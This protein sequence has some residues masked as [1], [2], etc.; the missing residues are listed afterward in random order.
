[1]IQVQNNQTGDVE[2][3]DTDKDLPSLVQSGAVSIPDKDYE[4]E[5]PEGD[6]YQVGAQG[7]L[8]AVKQG[9]KYR[10][11]DVL[12][13]EELQNKYGDSTAKALLYGGLRGATLGISDAILTKTGAVDPEELSAVKEFNP[14]ASNVG[15]IGAT[16]A[17]MLLSGGSSTAAGAISKKYLPSLLNETAEY[18]GKRAAA[19][20]TSNVAK[21]AVELGASG[22]IEGAAMGL[23]QTISEASLGDAE[24]NAESLLQNVGTGALIGGGLGATFGAGIEYAKKAVKG[25]TDLIK[26]QIIEHSDLPAAEKKALLLEQESKSEFSRVAN[27]VFEDKEFKELAAKNGWPTTPGMETNLKPF[28]TLEQ[29]IA[30]GASAPAVAIQKKVDD[31]YS[32]I[33]KEITKTIGEAKDISP[34]FAGDEIKRAINTDIDSRIQPARDFLKRVHE[35]MG[36]APVSDIIKTRL[37][38]RLMD[39]QAFRIGKGSPVVKEIVET[40]PTIQTLDDLEYFRK[41]VGSKLSAARRAGDQDAANILGD[42]YS[43]TKRAQRDSIGKIAL[44]VGPKKGQKLAKEVLR[45]YDDAYKTYSKV[46]DDYKPIADMLGLKI[47]NADFFLDNLSEEASETIGKRLLDLNDF[48]SMQKLYKKQP[49]IYDAA[50]KV[51]LANLAR[52]VT[53]ATTGDISPVRFAK[54]IRNLTSDQRSILFGFDGKANARVDELLKYIEKAPKKLNKSDT[55]TAQFFQKILSPVY[56]GTEYA[57]YLLYKGGENALKKHMIDN[58]PV[59]KVIETTANKQKN[60]I[61][62]SINGFFKASELGVTIGALKMLSDKDMDKARESYET[63]QTDPQAF[64]EKYTQNNKQLMGA[65]PNTANALQQ[66]I[67][68]GVQFLQSKVPHKDQD[69]IGEKIEPSRTELMKFNDY[70]EAVEK[71]QVVYEQLKQG[72]LNPSTLETLRTVYPKTY[73]SIQAEIIAKMPKHLTR[74]QKIQLQPILG[75]R[76]TPAMDYKNLMFLQNKTQQSAQANQQA[77]AQISHV[78]VSAA[79]NMKVSGRSQTGLDKVLNRT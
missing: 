19:N 26:K 31:V 8:D 57:R 42:V 1:M 44:T 33:D 40:L 23:S 43:T 46:F 36:N 4:F 16:I 35:E 54:K 47:T 38:N 48:E 18:V 49:E 52:Q 17:P 72:Y 45:A 15:E 59:Y 37:T 76:V 29:S 21:T 67:I 20:I 66:R 14:I 22:A 73:E 63:V 61:A 3:L 7:F 53:D 5:T 9:W 69:Y 12:K 56:Q 71:P 6:K 75:S 32:T 51:H 58:V 64:I 30:E 39:T 11:Q 13:H 70:L 41:K 2:T 27:S 79:K 60:K 65:A 25:G 10:D 78:P 62:S 50:R 55:A 34:R 68:A 28:Q 74:A 77:N 24:F